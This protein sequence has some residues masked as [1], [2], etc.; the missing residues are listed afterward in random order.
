V[1]DSVANDEQNT[2]QNTLKHKSYKEMPSYHV[3]Q[4]GCDIFVYFSL[5][6]SLFPTMTLNRQ[7]KP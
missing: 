5:N 4:Q 1:S 2:L 6:F 7:L 3:T